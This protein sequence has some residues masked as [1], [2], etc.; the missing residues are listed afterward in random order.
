[1]K[2]RHQKG[3]TCWAKRLEEDEKLGKCRLGMGQ[4]DIDSEEIGAK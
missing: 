3:E 4:R 1:M 2:G